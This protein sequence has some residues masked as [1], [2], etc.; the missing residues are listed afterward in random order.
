MIRVTPLFKDMSTMPL[1]FDTVKDNDMFFYSLTT[2]MC[3]LTK[4]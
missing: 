2:M 1:E 3:F 4:E